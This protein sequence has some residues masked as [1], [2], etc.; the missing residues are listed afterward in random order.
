MLAG[1]DMLAGRRKLPAARALPAP[2]IERGAL[3]FRPF[4]L[5]AGFDL[6]DHDARVELFGRAFVTSVTR[7]RADYGIAKSWVV[8]QFGAPAR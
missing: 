5:P 3:V 8:A 2:V 7:S 4:A 1:G 6:R